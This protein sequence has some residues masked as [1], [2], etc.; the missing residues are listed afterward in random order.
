VVRVRTE[1]VA[2]VDIAE[3]E[4]AVGEVLGRGEFRLLATPAQ[5]ERALTLRGGRGPEGLSVSGALQSNV[6]PFGKE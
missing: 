2:P 1:F 6:T 5:L 4:L 3:L